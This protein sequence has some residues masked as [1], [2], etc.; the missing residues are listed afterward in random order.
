[1]R[2]AKVS[3]LP[4]VEL[5]P[6]HGP[7]HQALLDNVA[8]AEDWDELHHISDTVGLDSGIAVPGLMHIVHNASNSLLTVT[9]TFAEAVDKLSAVADMLSKPESLKRLLATCFSDPIGSL[10]AAALR[11]FVGHVHKERWGTIA[12][13]VRNI[14]KIKSR[15][16]FG[17]N[18][19]SY[20]NDQAGKEVRDRMQLIDEAIRSDFWWSCI[21]AAEYL[22]SVVRNCLIWAESCPCHH[23]LLNLDADPSLVRRWVSCPMRGRR[24]P[25]LAAGD[26]DDAFSELFDDG[27]AQLLTSIPSTISAEQRAILAQDFSR[28][29]AHLVF[30]FALKTHAMHTPPR[31]LYAAAH[32]NRLKSREALRQCLDHP[33]PHKRMRELNAEPLRSQA[34]A[35]L[36][37]GSLDDLVELSSFLGTLSFGFV[38]ERLVEGDHAAIHRAFARARSHSEAFD[39]LV[40]RMPEIKRIR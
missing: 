39:S 22:M 2:S 24:L 19:D 36:G 4:I 17:W 38:V 6:W 25:E 27:L 3:P 23:H 11:A 31:L 29:R 40:R 7:A 34:I 5:F 26:F 37:G 32:H 10:H 15:L 18:L 30:Q 28:G 1:M 21:E 8:A 33:C 12:T 14:L 13:C 9:T 20:L 35:Y 16:R